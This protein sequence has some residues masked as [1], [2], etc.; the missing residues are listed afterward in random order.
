MKYVKFFA[1]IFLF[2]AL[3]TCQSLGSLI[4]EPKL[5]L[6]SV[7][8]ANI[9]LSGIDLITHIDIENPN[10]FTL[11][12]PKIDWAVSINTNPF[13]NGIFSGG[14][15]INRQ[16]KVTVD[17]PINIPFDALFKTFSSLLNSKEAAYNIA[18]GIS[19]PYPILEN[20]VF[21]LSY[22]G[23]LPLPQLPK[24]SS[25]SVGIE[26]M[27]FS[28]LTLAYVAN[29]ENPNNFP[30]P[31]PKMDWDYS[32]GGKSV[33]KSSNTKTGQIAASSTG[34]VNFEIS[35]AYADIFN[36]ID[37]LKNATEAKSNLFLGADFSMPA[38]D[39]TKN[40]L[41]IPGTIPILQTPA[42]AFRGIT[43]KSLGRT[44]EFDL[45]LEVDN[46]NNFA[47]NLDNFLYD[48]KVNNSQWAQGKINN[49]PIVKAN[50]KT[51]IP[52][53]VS[54]SSTQVVTEIVDIIN[55][56]SAINYVCSGSANFIGD[57]PGLNI[58][59][60]LLNLQGSTRIQ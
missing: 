41:D 5:S 14:K 32:V 56:G 2:L 37:S 28:G 17:L 42:I 50:G 44:M 36:V 45:T 12:T 30:I 18:L 60:Y 46:K 13:I 19:F 58:P 54:V 43:R 16:E 23:Q 15:S 26:K 33:L 51:L 21:P 55:R 7:D 34:A 25:G 8:I 1:A 24:F 59:N 27:D 4:Q 40:T 38:F 49:P 20:M 9:T 47:F 35:I 48:F 6:R 53:T 11:P 31:L 57:L 39:E 22:S 29:I 10:S 52:F 3:T